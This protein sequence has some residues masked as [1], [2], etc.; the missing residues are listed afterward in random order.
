L[1]LL[2]TTRSTSRQ[3]DHV[4][5]GCSSEV[6]VQ[7]FCVLGELAGAQLAENSVLTSMVSELQALLEHRN[8]QAA[9]RKTLYGTVA[10]AFRTLDEM[11]KT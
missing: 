2:C 10:Q 3:R 5:G 9:E 11:E 7:R 4:S 1:G 6:C 8:S